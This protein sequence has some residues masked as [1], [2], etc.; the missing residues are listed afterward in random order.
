MDD[1]TLLRISILV[2]IVGLCGLLL[3]VNNRSE[4]LLSFSHIESQTDETVS[5]QGRVVTV[6]QIGNTTFLEVSFEDSASVVVFEP[7]DIQVGNQLLVEGTVEKYKGKKEI[8]AESI[9]R[10]PKTMADIPN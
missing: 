7:L 9:M 3:I 6:R 10:V 5:I 4:S 8:I 1:T 2:G